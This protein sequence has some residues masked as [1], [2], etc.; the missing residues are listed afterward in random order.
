MGQTAADPSTDAEAD[1]GSLPQISAR[2]GSL[3]DGR[4]DLRLCF[5][6]IANSVAGIVVT[7]GIHGRDKKDV[8]T[9]RRP[10]LAIGFS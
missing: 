8:F 5:L 3:K 4:F 7:V 6:L 10:D 1:T 2:I 9:V